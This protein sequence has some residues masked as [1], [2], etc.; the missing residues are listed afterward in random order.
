MKGKDPRRLEKARFLAA[1]HERR[2]SR[3]RP[4]CTPANIRRAAAELPERLQAIACDARLYATEKR[5]ILGGA[6]AARR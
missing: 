3:W 1:T 5:P 2:A 6:Q 4:G